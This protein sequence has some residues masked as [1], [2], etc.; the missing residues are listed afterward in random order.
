[1]NL[2]FVDTKVSNMALIYSFI[3]KLYYLYYRA[4]GCIEGNNP[5]VVLVAILSNFTFPD[6]KS[7]TY[8]AST[9]M[10]WHPFRRECPISMPRTTKFLKIPSTSFW[11]YVFTRSLKDASFR[12]APKNPKD[13]APASILDFSPVKP[14]KFTSKLI[15]SRFGLLIHLM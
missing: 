6:I 7:N 10:H 9:A 1:M 4:G 5:F 2:L 14:V 8:G 12:R 13:K 15:F 11:H 3:K